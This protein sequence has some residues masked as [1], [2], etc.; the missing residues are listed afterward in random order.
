MNEI[1]T[2]DSLL[3]PLEFVLLTKSPARQHSNSANTSE[4]KATS[5]K[6]IR[7]RE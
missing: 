4:K 5:I 3:W 7:Q 1:R 6:T 2:A